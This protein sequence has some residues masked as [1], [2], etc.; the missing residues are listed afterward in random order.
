MRRS[1]Y[2][3]ESFVGMIGAEP[4]FLTKKH[5]DA[6]YKESWVDADGCEVEGSFDTRNE[7]FIYQIWHE[8]ALL[9][10]HHAKE[11]QTPEQ[12]VTALDNYFSR[13]E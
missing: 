6:D 5:Q 9:Y 11:K 12:C 10:T 2:E 1:N 13:E 4:T 3:N 8:G 7:T